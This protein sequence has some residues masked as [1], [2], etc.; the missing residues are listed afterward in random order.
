MNLSGERNSCVRKRNVLKKIQAPIA[1]VT[2]IKGLIDVIEV[3]LP[4]MSVNMV[5]VFWLSQWRASCH[6]NG[7]NAHAVC[8][9]ARLCTGHRLSPVSP[10]QVNFSRYKWADTGTLYHT[11]NGGS[12][13]VDT[14]LSS[15]SVDYVAQICRVR[16]WMPWIRKLTTRY[17]GETSGGLQRTKHQAG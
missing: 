16:R 4:D 5:F 1:A 9:C 6:T 3:L 14:G 12:C 8:A 13:L 15:A 17:I 7:D 11:S 10:A 2:R